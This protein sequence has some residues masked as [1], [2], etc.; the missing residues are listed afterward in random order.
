VT[1]PTPGSA[2]P[3]EEEPTRHPRVARAPE[4]VEE[5]P[6][7]R[8]RARRILRETAILT[9][10]ALVIA[11]LLK[12]FLVQAF[13]IPSASMVPTLQRGDRILVNRL[14]YRLGDIE[15]FDIVV[16]SDPTPDPHADRGIVGGF[17]HWLGEGLGFARPEDEDFVKRVLAL[18]GETWEIREGRLFV[19]GERVPEPFL[20]GPPDERSFGPETVPDGMLFVMG[21]NRLHSTDS[22]WPPP[23]GL[24]Y[25]PVDKVV[26]QAFVIVWP[27]SRWN[28]LH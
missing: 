20:E 24:G 17:L 12:T 15:R 19:D 27:P 26:G 2:E 28:V 5:T 13:F 23:R 10:S 4:P 25:V 18:P 9:I 22:R 16:F 7:P 11:S 21:D 1:D 14:A 6:E 3:V 8:S